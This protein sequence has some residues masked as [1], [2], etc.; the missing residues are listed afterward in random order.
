MKCRRGK[1]F[2]S[3]ENIL[4]TSQRL[5]TIIELQTKLTTTEI[6]ISR[7]RTVNVEKESDW[8]ATSTAELL[9][10][11]AC[12]VGG[13]WKT[14]GAWKAGVWAAFWKRR[15]SSLQLLCNELHSQSPDDLL[16][17]VWTVSYS[18]GISVGSASV[19]GWG[20]CGVWCVVCGV[21][22][23]V[24]GV[25]R[26]GRYDEECMVCGV[27][28]GVWSDGGC[29]EWWGVWCDEVWALWWG[30]CGVWSYGGCLEWWGVWCDEVWAL[31]WGVCGV[32]SYGGCVVR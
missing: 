23:V 18:E 13:A 6:L 16:D 21:W 3:N 25:T 9:V 12:T 30:V 29:V 27:M 10:G 4:K 20:V 31:W 28:G 11:G 32:W 14:G 5:K 26:C 7:L 1:L 24:C 15:I 19:S 2:D 22:C 17:E 8:D